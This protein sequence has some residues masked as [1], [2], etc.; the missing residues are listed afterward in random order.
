MR[1]F[2]LKELVLSTNSFSFKIRVLKI[3]KELK[4]RKLQVR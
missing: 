2:S 3:R 1:E 4:V